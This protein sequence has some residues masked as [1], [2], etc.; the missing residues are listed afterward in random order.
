MLM[1]SKTSVTRRFQSSVAQY[2]GS[3]V[4]IVLEVG[5]C[6]LVVCD[7]VLYA[8]SVT[9]LRLGMGSPVMRAG[10]R[11]SLLQKRFRQQVCRVG[12]TIG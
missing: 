5:R 9:G 8:V 10:E 1:C 12:L 3:A 2:P 11:C 6:G 7:P 4:I